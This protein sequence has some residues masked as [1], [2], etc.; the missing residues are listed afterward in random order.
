MPYGRYLTPS[1]NIVKWKLKK[2]D[3][4]CHDF[5][6]ERFYNVLKYFVRLQLEK[7]SQLDGKLQYKETHIWCIAHQ[8]I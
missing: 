1:L 6:E 2:V 7:G 4:V 8:F 5:I 3:I